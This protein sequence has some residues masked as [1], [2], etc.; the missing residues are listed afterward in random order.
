M[1]GSLTV[2]DLST[3]VETTKHIRRVQE[4]LLRIICEL[5]V[6]AIKHD[7]SKLENPEVSVFSEYTPKLKNSVYLSDEYKIFLQEMQVALKHHYACNA[8]HPEHYSNGVDGMSLV[9]VIE[10]LC[11]WKAASERHDTGDVYKSIE[12]NATRFSL[13][14]QLICILK[15]TVGFL[16]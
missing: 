13:D 15:N 12:L 14:K 9:D 11:D 3:N 1:Q 16:K 4:L 10:M 8:H 6:R 2:L 7:A 5:Q